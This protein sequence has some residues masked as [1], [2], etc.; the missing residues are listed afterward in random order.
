[1]TVLTSRHQRPRKSIFV[2]VHSLRNSCIISE[3]EES[4]GSQLSLAKKY[5]LP[6][7]LHSRAAH[8]DF[9]QI[10]RE[11]GFGENGGQSVGGKGGVVHSFTGTV[12]EVIELVRGNIRVC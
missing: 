11:E 10:L 1:M 6:L 8:L 3:E 12:G 9:V 2:S 5:H 7:F 4:V